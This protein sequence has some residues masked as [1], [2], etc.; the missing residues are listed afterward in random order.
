LDRP[1]TSYLRSQRKLASLLIIAAYTVVV[2]FTFC[3]FIVIIGLM[4][5]IFDCAVYQLSGLNFP[6]YIDLICTIVLVLAFS[7]SKYA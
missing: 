6:L 3:V 1:K 5:G 7:G 4:I 2:V